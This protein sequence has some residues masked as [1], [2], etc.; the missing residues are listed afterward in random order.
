MNTSIAD[1]YLNHRVRDVTGERPNTAINIP[2]SSTTAR[3]IATS[4][5]RRACCPVTAE[6]FDLLDSTVV[7]SHIIGKSNKVEKSFSRNNY[8]HYRCLHCYEYV[9]NIRVVREFRNFFAVS[10]LEFTY[11]VFALY[12]ILPRIELQDVLKK[13]SN[14]QIWQ[15]QDD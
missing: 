12:F 4:D 8:M 7:P 10:H 15:K 3:S 5:R 11:P 1:A 6:H 13:Y 14:A 2:T 9:A